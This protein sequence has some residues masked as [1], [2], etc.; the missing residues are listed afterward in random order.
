MD[1]GKTLE[2]LKAFKLSLEYFYTRTPAPAL[3]SLLLAP[4]TGVADQWVREL[5]NT[6]VN[7]H[8]WIVGSDYGPSSIPAGGAHRTQNKAMAD[9][10]DPLPSDCN[11][12]AIFP[13]NDW[14]RYVEKGGN[15]HESQATTI[16]E[17]AG[18]KNHGEL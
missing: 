14:H 4:S 16:D 10:S 3:R 12:V 9:L 2:I 8:C 11:L 1:L 13:F 17:V 5:V 6:T 7:L 15:T 18:L